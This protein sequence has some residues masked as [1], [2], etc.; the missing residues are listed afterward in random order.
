VYQKIIYFLKTRY[1][2]K[3]WT[4]RVPLFILFTVA[5]SLAI[6]A[7]TMVLWNAII[8]AVFHA[9]NITLLQG[10]GLIVLSRLLFGGFRRGGGNRHFKYRCGANRDERRQEAAGK[11]SLAGNGNVYQFAKTNWQMQYN[12]GSAL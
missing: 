7:V 4:K 3:K 2:M 5:G 10:V 6:G 11:E 1:L 9:G 8:P 12:A